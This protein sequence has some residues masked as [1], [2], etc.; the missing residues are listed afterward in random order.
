MFRVKSTKRNEEILERLEQIE[1]RMKEI[2]FLSEEFTEL[3]YEY[4]SLNG[5]LYC[6]RHEGCIRKVQR[7]RQE[8]EHGKLKDQSAT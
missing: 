3:E 6:R 7:I 1:R 8:T 2:S 4:D 5:E